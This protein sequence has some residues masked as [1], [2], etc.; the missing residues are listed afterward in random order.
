VSSSG[1]KEEAVI[2]GALARNRSAGWGGRPIACAAAM[3]ILLLALAD[4]G[5]AVPPTAQAQPVR[6]EVSAVDGGGLPTPDEIASHVRTLASANAVID[7]ILSAN[8][9]APHIASMNFVARLRV[10]SPLS[11]A[12]T[13]VFEGAVALHGGRRSATITRQTPGLVCLAAGRFFIG[14]LFEGHEPLAA[15]LGRFDF[16]VLGW[17]VVDG[18]QYCL[19]QGT[20]RTPEDDPRAMIGWVDYERGLVIEATMRYA[21]RTIYLAQQYTSINGAAVLAHQDLD[22]PSLESTL[23]ISYSKVTLEPAPASR[24][25]ARGAGAVAAGSAPGR[26]TWSGRSLFAHPPSGWRER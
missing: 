18:D 17:K 2:A 5:V 25:P 6:S 20:A 24:V 21:A 12:P 3:S 10:R 1:S 13:C 19:V 11:A 22:M 7:R 9:S 15:L 23:Q 8:Q 4:G 26:L 14:K 16:Q